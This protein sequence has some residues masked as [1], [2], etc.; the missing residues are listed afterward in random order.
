MN[1][2]KIITKF[3]VTAPSHGSYVYMH[4]PCLR[5]E[6]THCTSLQTTLPPMQIHR[7][8]CTHSIALFSTLH[9]CVNDRSFPWKLHVHVHHDSAYCTA[10]HCYVPTELEPG[11]RGILSVGGACVNTTKRNWE[12]KKRGAGLYMYMYV[13]SYTCTQSGTRNYCALLV[14][15]KGKIIN[16]QWMS[17]A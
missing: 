4:M 2:K 1:K 8:P 12:Q 10:L 9:T 3:N 7:F 17:S 5:V 6:Q 13:A 11:S 16:R 14:S 15:G